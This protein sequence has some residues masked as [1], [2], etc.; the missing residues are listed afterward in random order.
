MATY[1]TYRIISLTVLA[2]AL[3]A[4]ALPS[5]A[6]TELPPPVLSSEDDAAA[7]AWTQGLF[8]AAGF[9]EPAA[10][11]VFSDGGEQCGGARGRTWLDDLPHVIAVVKRHYGKVL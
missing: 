6:A 4:Q 8:S 2:V 11:I 3:G 1:T 5:T 10:A 7:Y 9:E